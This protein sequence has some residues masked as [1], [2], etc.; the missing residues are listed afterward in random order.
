MNS[1]DADELLARANIEAANERWEKEI[2]APVL[3]KSP[4]RKTE[5]ISEA[6]IKSKIRNRW[7]HGVLPNK[8]ASLPHGCVTQAYVFRTFRVCAA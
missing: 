3:R 2:L 4:E 6:N 1:E 7:R 5:F 8:F